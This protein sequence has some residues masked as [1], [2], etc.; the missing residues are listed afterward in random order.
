MLRW[1]LNYSRVIICFVKALLVLE[2]LVSAMESYVGSFSPNSSRINHQ[3]LLHGAGL[4]DFIKFELTHLFF[5]PIRETGVQ[6]PVTCLRS[7]SK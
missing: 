5:H 6:K 2:L 3:C 1:R 4:K 7:L